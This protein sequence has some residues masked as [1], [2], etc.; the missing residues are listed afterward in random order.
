MSFSTF[1][2]TLGK[3]EIIAA[4]AFASGLTYICFSKKKSNILKYPLITLF[5]GT[6]NGS[7]YACGALFLREFMPKNTHFIIPFAL[8][9]STGYYT[10]IFNKYDNYSV[11][12]H[13]DECKEEAYKEEACEKK[14]CEEEEECEDEEEGENEEECEEKEEGENEEDGENEDEHEEKEECEEEGEDK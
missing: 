4:I 2:N 9:V 11:K 13:E 12:N 3:E 5:D 10:F 1:I 7:I 6:I 14:E 8:L